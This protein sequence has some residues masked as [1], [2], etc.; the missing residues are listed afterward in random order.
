MTA[1][2]PGLSRPVPELVEGLSGGAFVSATTCQKSRESGHLAAPEYIDMPV[3]GAFPASR[4]TEE[5]SNCPRA[6]A[7]KCKYLKFGV[8]S[9]AES[10]IIAILQEDGYGTSCEFVYL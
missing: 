2:C 3:F 4:C 10:Y 9:E 7:E 1:H 5:P 6:S 8:K